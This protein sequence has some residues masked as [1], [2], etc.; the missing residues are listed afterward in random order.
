[1]LKA[2]G[3]GGT[4]VYT[5]RG[6][7]THRKAKGRERRTHTICVISSQILNQLCEPFPG[8]RRRI[9]LRP[10]QSGK[11]ETREGKRDKGR[12][13][14]GG[15]SAREKPLQGALFSLLSSLSIPFPS[16]FAILRLM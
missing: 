11:E 13:E 14:R 4:I 8:P 9:A 15:E 3:K 6:M 16:L 10:K 1:M 12:G 7:Y 5:Q 2:C